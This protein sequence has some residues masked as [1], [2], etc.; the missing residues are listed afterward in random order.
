MHGRKKSLASLMAV[1][2]L[3]LA[4][5]GCGTYSPVAPS[6]DALLMPGAENPDFA[7]LLSASKGSDEVLRSAVASCVISAKDGGVVGNGYF[8]LY[9]PPGALEEDTEISIE[10]PEFPSAVVRL[11]PHGIQFKV[12]VTLSLDL[13]MVD[14]ASVVNHDIVWLNEMSGLWES[15]GCSIED[16]FVKSK[17]E[18]FSDYGDNNIGK[19]PTTP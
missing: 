14:P 8:S 6:N 11:S 4:A 1:S 12:P 16:G 17:L 7:V 3:M 19:T 18:H 10:M 2:F 9:F 5:L 15:I 13:A